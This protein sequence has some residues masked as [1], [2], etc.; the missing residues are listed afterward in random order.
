VKVVYRRGNVIRAAQPIVDRAKVNL[1]KAGVHLAQ[2]IRNN[3]QTPVFPRSTPFNFP[4]METTALISSYDSTPVAIQTGTFTWEVTV[5]SDVEYAPYLE[6]GAPGINLLPRP[7]LV[8]T[9][10]VQLSTL[11]SIVGR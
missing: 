7:H 11:T 6:Q 2:E 10:F 8:S 1:A 9:L 5:G 4:H 3:L